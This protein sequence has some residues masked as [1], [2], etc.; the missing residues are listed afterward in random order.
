[1]SPDCVRPS[2]DEIDGLTWIK[3]VSKKCKK[4][5]HFEC[6]DGIKKGEDYSEVVFACK[7]C[8]GPHEEPNNF[9]GFTESLQ[10]GR[11]IRGAAQKSR[12]LWLNKVANGDV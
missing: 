11:I 1:M 6:V 8:Y 12:A 2:P 10:N 7:K 5:F 3:C 9:L 4:W